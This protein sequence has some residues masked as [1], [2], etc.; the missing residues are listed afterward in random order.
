M[1]R[2]ALP[3]RFGIERFSVLGVGVSALDLDRAS[4]FVLDWVRQDRRTYVTVTG[5]HGV[6]EARQDPDFGRILDQAGMVTPDG[7][8]LVYVGRSRGFSLKRV[9]GPDLMLALMAATRD[10][11]VKHYF[12]G[13]GDGVAGLLEDRL[14]A[15][16]PGIAVAGRHTPPFRPLTEAEETGIVDRINNSGADIVWVGLS[17]PKQEVWMAR[18]RERLAPAVLIGV[19][20]AFDFHAGLKPQ[21]PRLMQMMALEWLFRLATEPRRL[22]RRYLRNNP[23]FLFD[24]FRETLGLKRFDP[25]RRQLRNDAF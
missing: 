18:M 17:T 11:S 4:G 15:R 10:G 24:L 5:V 13:G 16:F 9:Y 6:M 1:N 21:A 2:Y 25:P 3:S 23:L 14:R 7:M 12:Y 19:G 22:W 20:A 8:P